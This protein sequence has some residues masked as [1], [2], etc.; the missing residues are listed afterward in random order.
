MTWY[1][2]QGTGV[3]LILAISVMAGIFFAFR[4][5]TR[6]FVTREKVAPGSMRAREF[7]LRP[8]TSMVAMQV[9]SREVVAR[10]VAMQAIPVETL[11]AVGELGRSAWLDEEDPQLTSWWGNVWWRFLHFLQDLWLGHECESWSNPRQLWQALAS[12]E[13]D[14]ACPQSVLWRRR[15]GRVHVAHFYSCSALKRE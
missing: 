3:W 9:M 13:L 14:D 10:P 6:R 12:G 1:L 5:L 7:Y 8:W 11:L 4:L 15:S 2:L